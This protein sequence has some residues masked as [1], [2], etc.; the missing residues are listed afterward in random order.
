MAP[1]GIDPVINVVTVHWRTAKWVEPQLGYLQRNL[2]GPYRVFASLNEIDP[3]LG[4]RFY[5]ADEVEGGHG[6]KLNALAD[7]VAERAEEGETLVFLDGDAFPVRPL[8]PWLDDVL[9]RYPLCAVR[10]DENLGDRQP[11]PSLCA[12]TVGFWNEIGGDWR[13]AP[14]TNAAGREV[15]DAGGRLRGALEEHGVEWLPLLRTNTYNPHPLWFGVYAHRIYHHGAGFQ[16]ARAERVD[17]AERYRRV[18]E[19]GR[20]LRPTAERPSLGTLR[21]RVQDEGVRLGRLRPRHLRVAA[22]AAVKTFKLRREHR[23]FAKVQSSDRSR[24]L[25]DLGDRLFAELSSDPEFHR[26]FDSV[27]DAGGA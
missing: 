27:D 8:V 2:P 21:L 25:R 24:R 19:S 15:V 26:R 12:T 20:P 22:R 4:A 23:F 16:G 6:E 18:P 3:A 10:R 11:H 14:W 13:G 17:W 9:A 1:S 7:V 5:F